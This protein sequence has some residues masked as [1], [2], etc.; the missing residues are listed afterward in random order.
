[1]TWNILGT[2]ILYH[3]LLLK[4]LNIINVQLLRFIFME[5]KNLFVKIIPL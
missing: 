4:L 3:Y 5:I 1:M 2:H